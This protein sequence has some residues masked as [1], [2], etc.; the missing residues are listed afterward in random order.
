MNRLT[1]P[2]ALLLAMSA[3]ATSDAWATPPE[4]AKPTRSVTPAVQ[5]LQRIAQKS[6]ATVAIKPPLPPRRPG[7]VL[8]LGATLTSN[9]ELQLH[10]DQ[11]QT[12]ALPDGE[13]DLP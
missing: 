5:P 2:T 8:D 11:H 3:T 1:I 13:G 6:G 9:G 4:P 12:L 7:P 10:C